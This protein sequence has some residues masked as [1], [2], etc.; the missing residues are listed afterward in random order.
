MDLRGKTIVALDFSSSSDSLPHGIIQ[1]HH[2]QLTVLCPVQE[3]L[4][5]MGEGNGA[6]FQPAL[7]H[8]VGISEA[9]PKP[10]VH[11]RIVGP[12]ELLSML[13]GKPDSKAMA[14]FAFKLLH[15]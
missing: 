3:H 7:W 5:K 9:G 12:S 2:L 14:K 11:Y 8:E 1:D 15:T 6:K 13:K 10:K 4:A